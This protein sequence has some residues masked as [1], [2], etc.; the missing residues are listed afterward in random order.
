MD[1]AQARKNL[2]ALRRQGVCRF[3]TSSMDQALAHA[4]PVWET[5]A[6]PS[7]ATH[8]AQPPS[9]GETPRHSR[10]RLCY[11][12]PRPRRGVHFRFLAAFLPGKQGPAPS[13]RGGP[14]NHAGGSK[15][16]N[17]RRTAAESIRLEGRN[18]HKRKWGVA[19]SRHQPQYGVTE[20]GW[21]VRN[22][23]NGGRRGGL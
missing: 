15:A 2:P 11:M 16:Q 18:P 13:Q 20:A 14:M 17:S 1:P 6:R 19:S 9:A 3:A 8:V 23:A 5:L 21:R 22:K 10:G 4:T 12:A 7:A